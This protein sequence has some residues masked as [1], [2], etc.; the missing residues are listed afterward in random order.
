MHTHILTVSAPGIAEWKDRGS[1]FIAYCFPIGNPEE[2]KLKL[3]QVKEEHPKADHFCY[4][5]RLGPDKNQFRVSDAGEPS[6][7][8]G[9]PILQQIDRLQLTN[10]LVVVVRYFGGTL[11][12]V[13]GLMNA[14]KTAAGFALQSTPFIHK[15]L[16]SGFFLEYDYT[17]SNAVNLL[18][19][20]VRAAV[21]S[22]EA[23][24]FLKLSISVPKISE[25][26]FLEKICLLN[27]VLFSKI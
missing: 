6:G 21:N 18:L 26:A 22:K 4:A 3:K 13:G 25:P 17:R 20:Q 16:M 23:G 27:G 2:F 24:L 19:R 7:S 9:K 14:Y 15:E 1:K 10:I 11:L 8:A 12:G 5:Y